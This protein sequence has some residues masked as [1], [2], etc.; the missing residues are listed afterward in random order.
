MSF[1]LTA[2]DIKVVEGHILKA[3]LQDEHGAYHEQEFDLNQA[4]G[5]IHG[6]PTVL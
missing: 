4:I 6:K 3:E 1:H 2:R 5:N